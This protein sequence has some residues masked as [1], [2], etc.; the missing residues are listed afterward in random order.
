MSTQ[1]IVVYVVT[2]GQCGQTWERTYA[3]DDQTLECVFCGSH[4]Q[5]RLMTHPPGLSGQTSHFRI[6][7][8]LECRDV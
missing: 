2:C 7:A 3:S 4:G 6:E 1:S 5:L 8:R